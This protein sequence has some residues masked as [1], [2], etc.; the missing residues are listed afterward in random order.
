MIL[1]GNAVDIKSPKAALDVG[2]SMIHQELNRVR[3]IGAN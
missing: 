3:G 1:E 2:I